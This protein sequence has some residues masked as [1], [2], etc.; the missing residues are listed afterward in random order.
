[1]GRLGVLAVPLAGFLG[2]GLDLVC[3][4]FSFGHGSKM[5]SLYLTRGESRPSIWVCFCPWVYHNPCE[6]GSWSYDPCRDAECSLRNHAYHTVQSSPHR[7]SKTLQPTYA[8]LRAEPFVA[9][10][11]SSHLFDNDELRLQLFYVV[12][13]LET[14]PGGKIGK[15]I[16]VG[17]T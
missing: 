15:G 13:T 12:Q 11:K 9:C 3:G 7:R 16:T 14:S 2:L 8:C 5:N 17:F 10:C 4:S 6:H 1:M